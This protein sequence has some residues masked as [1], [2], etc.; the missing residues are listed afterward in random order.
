MFTSLAEK[1]DTKTLDEIHTLENEIGCPLLAFTFFDV[2]PAPLDEKS[3]EKIKKFEEG[4][5]ICLLAV[6]S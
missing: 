2:E 5:C 3:L 1:I 6:T 4:R